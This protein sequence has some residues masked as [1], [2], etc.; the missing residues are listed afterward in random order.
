MSVH[1]E[2]GF[3]FTFI[4]EIVPCVLGQLHRD[5]IHVHIWHHSLVWFGVGGVY[6]VCLCDSLEVQYDLTHL[7]I[8]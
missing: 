4:G 7:I 3:G 6:P 2:D 1:L 5:I 8:K